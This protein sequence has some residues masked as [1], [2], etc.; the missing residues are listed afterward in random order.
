MKN[1]KIMIEFVS[2]LG[3]LSVFLFIVGIILIYLKTYKK[4][5]IKIIFISII[6]FLVCMFLGFIWLMNSGA[7]FGGGH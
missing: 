5:G 3:V 6:T 7:S 4:N 2:F 1:I